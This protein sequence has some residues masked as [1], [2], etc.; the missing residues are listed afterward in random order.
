MAL[1]VGDYMHNLNKVRVHMSL[2]SSSDITAHRESHHHQNLIAHS[3]IDLFV[4]S[5]MPSCQAREA[6]V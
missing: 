1:S 6:A 4:G 2:L 5:V 3:P